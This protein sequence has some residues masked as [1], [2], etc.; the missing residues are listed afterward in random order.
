[1]LLRVDLHEGCNLLPPP[2]N[3]FLQPIAAVPV[4]PKD[5]VAHGEIDVAKI[6]RTIRS[7]ECPRIGIC[8]PDFVNRDVPLTVNQPMVNQVV[9]GA[10]RERR[11]LVIR[12]SELAQLGLPSLVGL[13]HSRECHDVVLLQCIPH[14]TQGN[15]AERP[16]D[17]EQLL[18]PIRYLLQQIQRPLAV[19]ENLGR[20]Q[21]S[22]ISHGINISEKSVISDVGLPLSCVIVC[23]T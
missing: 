4:A 9:Q 23:K 1:M 17:A 20:F 8:L 18:V 2:V 10:F 3:T 14:P 12:V 7:K 19:V 16:V 15:E 5:D 11:V 6:K 22:G 13:T 21:V